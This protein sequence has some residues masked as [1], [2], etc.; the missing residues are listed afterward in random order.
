MAGCPKSKSICKKFSFGGLSETMSCGKN[1][2]WPLMRNNILRSDLEAVA[3]FLNSEDPILTQSSNVEKF[4]EEW[5][6]WLGA[7]HSVFVNSG[8]SANLLTMA[9]L[10]E[11]R[12]TGEVIVPTLTWVSDIASVIQCGFRPV[13][14]DIDRLTLGMA[15]DEVLQKI[16]PQTKAVFLTHI[17]G[18]NAL[19]RRLLAELKARDVPLIEDV[20]ESYGATFEGRKLGTF[21]WVSNFS[22]YYAHHM[23]TIEGGI[24]ATDDA[25]LYQAL[26]ML[27]SHG[28]V[29]EAK[30]DDLKQSYYRKHPDLNPDFIF[31]F[32]AY[33]VRST[34][35][36]AVIGRSQLKRL[37]E[38]N[39]KRRTNLDLFLENLDS[40]KYQTEFATEGSCNYAF[41]LILRRPDSRLC[42][43]VM[44]T[45]RQ[46]GVEFRRGTS[47][48]GNQLRQPYLK[49][50]VGEG[51]FK[52]YP[53]VDH[54]HF[55]GFYIGN[56]PG[57]EREKILRLC[58]LLNE[59]PIG[60]TPDA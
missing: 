33:N 52:N 16:T 22:F 41:T 44:R 28:M 2:D 39:H 29:R 26:R 25:A 49:K 11:R 7:R 3:T 10:R 57:L 9:A 14:V 23:S 54:I 20:C 5:S 24:I 43:N 18:Y 47:G 35:I 53:N 46:H 45:L 59:I 34:E 55:Y 19:N 31:A 6:R 15:T 48:G 38:N 50:I 30:S 42:E 4:E 51:E 1:L 12:G 17:L 60:E 58:A 27:R 13:F 36:N 21:G 56:F 32:P 40:N 8:S 37:D